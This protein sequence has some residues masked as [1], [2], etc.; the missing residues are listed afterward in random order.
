[1]VEFPQSWELMP[2]SEVV[3]NITITGKKIPQ[4]SYLPN[5]KYPVFD[6]G[7]EFVG[8]Y[9][10]DIAKVVECA[11]PVI[12]FGDHTRV[13]KL[14][15]T[16]F[17]PGADGVKVLQPAQCFLPTLLEYFVRYLVTKIPNN[18][19]ARHYQHLAKSHIPIPP[20]A[21]QHRIVAKIEELFSELDKGIE[22]LKTARE[23]LKVYRQALLK[24][25]FEGKLT[26]QWREQNRDKLETAD[27]LLARIQ[28]ERAQRY[29][30]QLAEWE[31]AGKPGSKPKAPKSLPPLTDEELAELP[32]LP[33]GWGWTRVEELA[34]KVT[35]G[36]HVTPR[37]TE[38]G[39][40]LLSARNIQ[41]GYLDLSN[42]D[43]VPQDEYERIRKRCNPEEGDI[44]IS[45]S[46]SIGRICR[47]PKDLNFVMVRS[48]AVVKLQASVEASKFYEYLFQ[49]SLLQRQIEKGKK[50][51]AQANLFLE[52]IKNLKVLI[53][54]RKE[55]MEIIRELEARLSE[56]DQLD[57]TITTSLQQAEALRQSILKKAFSGQL[58]A[59]DVSEEPAAVLLARIKLEKAAQAVTVKSRK[60]AIKAAPT[61]TN[62]IPFPV[63]V[64]GISHSELH[65][66]IMALAYQQHERSRRAW[67]FGHVK[68]E[69]ISHMVESFLGI[70]LDRKPIKDAAGPNDFKRLLAVESLA[71][72]Q[73]WFD[74]QKQ[75]S[76][77][78][79]LHKMEGFDDLIER[80]SAALGERLD[81]V[82]VLIGHFIGWDKTRAEIV[83][84]V[85]A[86]WNNL[87][88]L[89]RI[90]SDEE[91]VLEATQN[92]HVDKLKIRRERFFN[93]LG[94]MRTY[95]LVPKG[96][97]RYV[98]KKG[99]KKSLGSAA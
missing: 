63:K 59:Q 34:S 99:E 39:Y 26:A 35:D 38:S 17:A 32:K 76:G 40:Y 62:V 81:S 83:A 73:K 1:M 68:A 58:V 97:G 46:G 69:K 75:K 55:Q 27:A 16:A 37:R 3:R 21:E 98:A 71:R 57:Q 79:V 23:Q 72:E 12:V 61:K 53:C 88:L 19:Y 2:V 45:C 5:G 87:L 25:A 48:V 24:H 92:W 91:I 66:G 84:T 96:R 85:Y 18:G 89:G 13:V 60:T 64:S 67:Y 8:G 44:L 42:V 94:W 90:P 80:T 95:G 4:K 50:A 10:D 11:L 41:N 70:D 65:A 56:V 20:L 52:P 86:A 6:Q 74:V 28:T 77:R 33:E 54:S 43:Y 22:S 51:T 7:Q 49:S 31:A 78:H 30:Q 47:V 9:T 29:Q 14:V 82:K 36:E 93:C 15:K